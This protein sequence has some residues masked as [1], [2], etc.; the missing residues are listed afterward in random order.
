MSTYIR[1]RTELN[2]LAKK[3]SEYVCLSVYAFLSSL[4]LSS[5][6]FYSLYFG[7]TFTFCLLSSKQSLRAVLSMP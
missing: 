6:V 1:S 7:L 4:C 5:R 3:V 2:H